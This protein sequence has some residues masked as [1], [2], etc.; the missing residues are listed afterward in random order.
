M[1]DVHKFIESLRPLLGSDEGVEILGDAPDFAGGMRTV[2]QSYGWTIDG[3]CRIHGLVSGDMGFAPTHI[4]LEKSDILTLADDFRATETLEKVG[5]LRQAISDNR[6][7]II[8]T[9]E[10]EDLWEMKTAFGI[11]LIENDGWTTPFG[12]KTDADGLADAKE[13]AAA[14]FSARL[15]SAFDFPPDEKPEGKTSS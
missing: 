14:D 1:S 12:V 10:G 2:F 11:Y 8:F 4:V 7:P 15:N 5:G 13:Q 9:K 3:D 6:K